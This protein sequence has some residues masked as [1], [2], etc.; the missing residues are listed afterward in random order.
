MRSRNMRHRF[1]P[2]VVTL[3]AVALALTLSTLVTPAPLLGQGAPGAEQSIFAQ[4]DKTKDARPTPHLADGHVN[5]GPI[6][7]E[8][9]LWLPIDARITIPDSG[10]ARG[11]GAG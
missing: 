7:G 6:P 2:L 1:M 11:P 4:G 8:T 9:G 3:P 5:F 10:P